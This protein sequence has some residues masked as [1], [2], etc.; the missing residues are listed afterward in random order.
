MLLGLLG[1]NK[2]GGD[3]S[4]DMSL[5]SEEDMSEFEDVCRLIARDVE[6]RRDG[7]DDNDDDDSD[8][9]DNSDDDSDED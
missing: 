3:D 1:N 4:F 6:E 2:S 7:G 9:D 5:V 8:D